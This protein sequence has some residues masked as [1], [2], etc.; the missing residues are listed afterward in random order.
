VSGQNGGCSICETLNLFGIINVLYAFAPF[1][2][3]SNFRKCI[4]QYNNYGEKFQKWYVK[5]QPFNHDYLIWHGK[6][7]GTTLKWSQPNDIARWTEI[8]KRFEHRC[9][10]EFG[11]H[12][13]VTFYPPCNY[14]GCFAG[15]GLSATGMKKAEWDILYSKYQPY[16]ERI[17]KIFHR[18]AQLHYFAQI[19]GLSDEH[20]LILELLCER[21]TRAQ[22]AAILGIEKTAMRN[23]LVAIAK[24]LGC[25]IQDTALVS[26][27]MKLSIVK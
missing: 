9:E 12:E 17:C 4:I 26:A 3:V 18:R 1:R 19:S 10:D 5:G 8:Q 13:G 15:I 7:V 20:V 22:I 14:R 24:K 21:K 6:T 25:P 11:V 27:A 16:L 2:D 23:R